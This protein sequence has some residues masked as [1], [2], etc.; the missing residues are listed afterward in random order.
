L[1]IWFR[2]WLSQPD[3]VNKYLPRTAGDRNVA[4]GSKANSNPV[5][6]GQDYTL[7]G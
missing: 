5:N 7:I 6:A 1:R 3:I 4:L 2:N